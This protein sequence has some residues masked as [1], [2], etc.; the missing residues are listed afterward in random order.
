MITA[1]SALLDRKTRR[2]ILRDPARARAVVRLL[3]AG[4]SELEIAVAL[5]SSQMIVVCYQLPRIPSVCQVA[6]EVSPESNQRRDARPTP[7]EHVRA[8][9]VPFSRDREGNRP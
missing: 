5:K 9:S 6:A 8:P 1:R 4:I 7:K 2:A 3:D